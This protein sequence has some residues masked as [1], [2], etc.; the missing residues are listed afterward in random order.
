[1]TKPA[2]KKRKTPPK[3]K[4]RK[5][6]DSVHEPVRNVSEQ[7]ITCEAKLTNPDRVIRCQAAGGFFCFEFQVETLYG[8]Q[9]QR[10]KITNDAAWLVWQIIGAMHPDVCG[11]NDPLWH[12][13]QA[14]KKADT[15]PNA[16]VSYGPKDH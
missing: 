6:E 7:V 12:K 3:P 11:G 14:A 2:I 4:V 15:I 9:S 10:L 1:M 16:S 5:G 8:P 13:Y